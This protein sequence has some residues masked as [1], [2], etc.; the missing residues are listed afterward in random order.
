MATPLRASVARPSLKLVQSLPGNPAGWRK[1]IKIAGLTARVVYRIARAALIGS[2]IAV[3]GC[4][5]AFL[6][7]L[8]AFSQNKKNGSQIKKQLIMLHAVNRCIVG[9]FALLRA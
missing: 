3:M 9:A 4:I 2:A 5:S 6:I 1:V 7:L 8:F